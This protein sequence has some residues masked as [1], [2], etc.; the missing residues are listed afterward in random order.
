MSWIERPIGIDLGTTNSCA[1]LLDLDGQ[2]LMLAEDQYGRTIVPSVIGFDA[3]RRETISGFTAWNRR[4]IA[5][6]PVQ[7][8]KRKMG[9]EQTLQIGDS[10][11]RS[12]AELSAEILRAMR[13]QMRGY[14][15][16]GGLSLHVERA[17]ITV[18]AYFDAPQIDATRRAGELSGFEVL[19]L[20]QEPTAACMYVV[21]KR[22]LSDGNFLVYDLGGGTFD[23]SIIRSLYGEYQV[24]GIHGDNYLGGD[25]FDRRLAE[26]LRQHLVERGYSLD[27][28]I[29]GNEE[30]RI[31]FLLLTRLAREIKESLSSSPVQYIARRDIFVDHEGAQV[32]LELELSREQWNTLMSDLVEST[33]RCCH[34]ALEHSTKAAGVSLAEIDHVVLVGGSTRSPLVQ[35]RVRAAFCGE[36]KSQ[37]QDLIIEAPDSCV[38]LGA[39]IHAANLGGAKLA[40][41]EQRDL[42]LQISSAMSTRRDRVR[43]NA[44]LAGPHAPKV[45][46]AMLLDESGATLAIE[47]PDEKQ[48]LKFKDIP[49]PEE[50]AHPMRFEF[51]DESGNTVSALDATFYRDTELRRTG[52]ALSNPT[53]LAKDIYLEVSRQGQLERKI[54]LS[55][56]KSLPATGAQRLFTGD[57]SGAV[58]L[59]LQQNRYPISSIHLEVPADLPIGTPVTLELK[60]DEKMVITASG[61]VAGRSFWA[62]IEPPPPKKLRSWAQIET[63]IDDAESL[64][65]RLWGHEDYLYKQ[66][67][68]FLITGI[69]EAVRTDPDKLQ[70][71]VSRLEALLETLHGKRSNELSPGYDRFAVML[72][73][74]RRV[75][76]RGD[77]LMGTDFDTWQRRLQQLEAEGKDAFDKQDQPRWSRCYTQAQ[78]L[79][80]SI[81]QEESRFARSDTP[82]YFRQLYMR[83]R[84][85]TSNLRERLE[86]YT[87]PAN[88]ETR[89]LHE[90]TIRRLNEAL[91][92]LNG[93]LLKLDPSS[94]ENSA[95]NRAELQRLLQLT[96]QLEKRFAQIPTLGVVVSHE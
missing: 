92:E 79:Y 10:E 53:V 80:E 71:L 14:L 58:V 96:R 68:P 37:A 43:V 54:L 91:T 61:E 33:I 23:V 11:P 84:L 75:A 18:P 25:D 45:Q 60:V 24:I 8:I 73:N 51:L 13:A 69:R 47:S 20:L 66:E 34:S 50:G 88:P 6:E 72:N 32:S 44:T 64:S 27:L 2:R 17:V 67:A 77:E 36:G 55:R 29:Q 70:V 94:A 57:Q 15:D 59:N 42:E 85:R 95:D 4:G 5:P 1:A 30:D 87:L 31:R 81:H 28:D 74:I 26:H 9:L 41:D 52:S 35:E 46:T 62:Q 3:D 90:E 38:A 22:E 19:G 76:L 7:S 93:F 65:A 16:R 78:A 56:G 48:R 89:R 40:A 63:L 21:W 83:A 39:A 12:P 49:L 86:E 82:E